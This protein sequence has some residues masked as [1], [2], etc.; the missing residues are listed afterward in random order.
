MQVCVMESAVQAYV[1][2][3]AHSHSIVHETGRFYSLIP[4]VCRSL[5][6]CTRE[7]ALTI[8]GSTRITAVD[9]RED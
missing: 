8:C 5:Q 3:E 9:G 4:A 1:D 7:T 2:T 6:S